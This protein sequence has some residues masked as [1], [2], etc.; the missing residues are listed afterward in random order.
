MDLKGKELEEHKKEMKRKEDIS[1][2]INLLIKNPDYTKELGYK[3]EYVGNGSLEKIADTESFGIHY[4]CTECGNLFWSSE[5]YFL[6]VVCT[7][8]KVEES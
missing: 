1:K 6:D 3:L 2:A 7:N 4:E 5:T 8:C